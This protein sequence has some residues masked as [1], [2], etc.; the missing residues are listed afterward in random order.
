MQLSFGRGR[1]CPHGRRCPLTLPGRHCYPSR[2]EPVGAAPTGPALA[3]SNREQFTV[4]DW[5]VPRVIFPVYERLSGRRL[6]TE[7]LRLRALQWRPP[8]ELEARAIQ[9]LRPLLAHAMA[10]VPYYRDLFKQAGFHPDDLRTVADLSRV[11]ITTKATLRDNFPHRT[12]AENLP[13]SRRWKMTT[14]GSTGSLFE[15]Y[16]DP[17]GMDSWDSSYLFF[18]EWA[19]AAFWDPQIIISSPPH[20]SYR[21]NIPRSPMLTQGVRR[22]LL[23]QR[24]VYLPGM[25]ITPATLRAQI[26]ALPPGRSYVI[27]TYPSYAARLAAQLLEE[28]VG[29]PAYPK[30]VISGGETLTPADAA[31]IQAAFHCPV[32]NHYSTW[33]VPHMAQTCPDNPGLVHVN[34]E[35]VI[36]RVVR[37]DG[38]PAAPGEP[39]R[40]VITALSNFTMPFINYELDDWAVAGEV[41]SCGRGL[42]TLLSL[43][44]RAGE[45]IRTPSGRVIAPTSLGHFLRLGC[46]AVPYIWEFQGVQTAAGTVVLRVVPT[47][48]FTAEFARTLEDKLRGFLGPGTKVRVETVDVIPR[49]ASGKRLIIKS[50]L[51]SH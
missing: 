28:G 20:R 7:V 47:P 3:G 12:T 39:G 18:L 10:H 17:A 11:P 38:T 1:R 4:Y 48:R 13:A 33:E 50:E 27:R 21:A 44:G 24:A 46:H 31:T 35:R 36:L 42:P 25:E 40:V 19:G 15:F 23:G 51:P 9:K 29:L 22:L 49:E 5:W 14:S 26:G 16:A 43:E 30:V 34:S 2:V 6:W 32:L 37:D 8:E 41:C 45:M